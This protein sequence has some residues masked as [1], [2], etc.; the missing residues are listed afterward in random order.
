M[1]EGLYKLLS[2]ESKKPKSD[3]FRHITYAG[4]LQELETEI[5]RYAL[6]KK[7]IKLASQ[8]AIR[9]MI[10]D[11]YIF[12]PTMIQSVLALMAY[13]ESNEVTM[14]D[15]TRAVLRQELK[16]LGK[17][18]VEEKVKADTSQTNSVVSA[19]V[20]PSM[21]EIFH[22]SV[23]FA[24]DRSSDGVRTSTV[25]FGPELVANL[26]HAVTMEQF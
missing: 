22:K 20:T 15:S 19:T 8:I 16:D 1:I 25:V 7:D 9:P 3:L 10:E 12:Y 26:Q 4:R 13:V 5:I 14:D 23:E 6:L 18:V 24:S 17:A 21:Q 2:G 11:E